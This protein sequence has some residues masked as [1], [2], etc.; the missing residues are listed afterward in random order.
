[1]KLRALSVTEITQYIKRTLSLDPILANVVVEGELSNFKLHSSGHAYFSLKDEGARI[2]CVMFHRAFKTV[3]FPP[4]DGQ[5]LKAKGYVSVYE[6]D[7]R[8]QLYVHTLEQAGL[9]DLHIQFEEL[10]R[11]LAS[12]GLFEPAKKKPVPSFPR[13]I[14]L[15]T[16]PTGAAVRDIIHVLNRR[17]A[18]ANIEIW[19]V[20]VQGDHA[21][22]EI[23]R[24]IQ[25]INE[26]E[27]ADVIVLSRGGGSIEELWAFNEERTAYAVSD[28]KI[29]VITG[30]GHET[31]TTIVDFVSDLRA[32]TPS[33]AAE[34]VAVSQMEIEERLTST[35]DRM[36][37]AM[38]HKTS[39]ARLQ[40]ERLSPTQLTLRLQRTADERRY[41][42]GQMLDKMDRQLTGAIGQ[43]RDRLAALG[44]MLEQVS[45]LSTLNRGYT[46]TRD[47][48]G[49]I[50]K[51]VDDVNSGDRI[52]I[53]MAD[54]SVRC[55]VDQTEK[56]VGAWRKR[57]P[58]K[59]K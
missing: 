37:R 40:L 44:Q 32:P 17:I 46:I 24:A 19:P 41:A 11:K 35:M 15:V 54:G 51:T 57:H 42:L 21:S 50:V 30:V 9:G 8:Y 12:E 52:Q 43:K 4:K 25:R 6:R 49:K 2:P 13:R 14:A 53:E 7:G 20:R 28:S 38:T 23:E 34:V 39:A 56:G 55:S 59:I 45:P 18:Y 3:D 31:D 26:R 47:E 5:K 58:L 1:M 33:A 10:K 29:P 36:Q 22:G 48:M 27:T 16:S